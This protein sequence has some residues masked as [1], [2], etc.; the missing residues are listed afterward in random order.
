MNVVEHLD[1]RAQI[2]LV[3][4]YSLLEY[5]LGK[6]SPGSVIGLIFSAFKSKQ[7]VQVA[8]VQR[9]VRVKQLASFPIGKNITV[10]V[11][12]NGPNLEASVQATFG[13]G[14]VGSAK[15]IVA[16]PV[17]TVLAPLKDAF[18]AELQKLIPGASAWDGPLIDK[19]WAAASVALADAP[20]S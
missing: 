1:W 16:Y 17:A 2:V 4:A 7:T 14:Q 15:L 9:S 10:G 12:V 18:V 5:F 20:A 19:A 3:L 13:G 8:P 11:D 6:S